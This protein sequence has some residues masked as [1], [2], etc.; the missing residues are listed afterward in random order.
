MNLYSRSVLL[1][2]WVTVAL[3]DSQPGAPSDGQAPPARAA[4]AESVAR[5]SPRPCTVRVLALNFD[6]VLRN[7]GNVRLSR[8]MKWNDPKEAIHNNMNMCV[9]RY[10]GHME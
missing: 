1:L 9:V 3:A 2:A 7:H 10:D 4:A 5:R 8:F 6:P